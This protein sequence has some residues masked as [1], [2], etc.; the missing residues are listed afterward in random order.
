MLPVGFVGVLSVSVAVQEK[1][2][3]DDTGPY[4]VVAGWFKPLKTG[5]L[6]R[7]CGVFAET[8]NRVFVTTDLQFAPAGG[9]GGAAAAPRPA[10][11]PHPTIQVLDQ[12][13]KL[14][15]EWTQWESLL[16]MPHAVT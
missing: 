3:T 12:T 2:G 10:P 14:V 7:G 9:G 6:E 4:T 11:T 13:G 5:F 16:K 15:E 1:G 8:P